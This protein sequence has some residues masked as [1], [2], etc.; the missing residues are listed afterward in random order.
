M[1]LKLN[2]DQRMMKKVAADFLKAEAPSYTITERFEKKTAFMVEPYKKAASIGW[3]GMVLPE[4]YG[5]GSA[6][7]T[8]CAVVFEELGRG[9]MPGPFFSCG[10]LAALIVAEGGS[11]AQKKDL[12]PKICDASAILVPAISDDPIQWGPRSVQTRLTQTRNGFTLQG[13][14]KYV[15]DAEAA[16][17]FICAAR[18]EEGKVALVLVDKQSPGVS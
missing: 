3:L 2:E 8:D 10:I 12:L 5:G 6:S 17:S 18:T 13:T 9:P 1:D 7:L 15:Y 4:D 16:T 14:K 11:D